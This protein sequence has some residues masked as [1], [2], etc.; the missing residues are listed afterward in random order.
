MNNENKGE[1]VK[2]DLKHDTLEFTELQDGTEP[3]ETNDDPL[4][5][6][7]DENIQAD[8][9][10]ALEDDDANEAAA[11]VATELDLQADEDQLPEEDWTDDLPDIEDGEELNHHRNKK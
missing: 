9:L 10:E 1:D 3:I 11:L 7:D 2:T 8:E 5:D 6:P 4:N